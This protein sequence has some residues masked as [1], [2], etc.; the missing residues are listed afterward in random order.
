MQ[1]LEALAQAETEERSKR[2]LERRL[3]IS[4]LKSF[5]PMADFDWSWPKK[6]ERDIIDRAFTLSSSPL[7]PPNCSRSIFPNFGSGT[8]MCTVYI[9]FLM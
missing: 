2:S 1:I 5:K 3:R 7:A 9:S 6:I 4:G 8:P